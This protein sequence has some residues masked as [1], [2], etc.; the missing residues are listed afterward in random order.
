MSVRACSASSRSPPQV[1][2]ASRTC[3][4]VMCPYVWT[5]VSVC[6]RMPA[7]PLSDKLMS[8]ID[9]MVIDEWISM[10]ESR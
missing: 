9:M 5:R 1:E 8:M 7:C 3:K 6:V 2:L 4:Q 10:S